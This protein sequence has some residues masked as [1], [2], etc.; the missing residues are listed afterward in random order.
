MKSDGFAGF[1][2]RFHQAA[3]R[4]EESS[5]FFIVLFDAALE[6]GQ[7]VSQFLVRS[8][9]LAQA[10]ESADHGNTCLNGNGAVLERWRS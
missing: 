1:A 10:D 4:F 2:W 3:D 5:D 8:Q 9:K 6:F 7:L